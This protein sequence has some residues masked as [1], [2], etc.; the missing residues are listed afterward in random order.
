[1]EPPPGILV[2]T[3]AAEETGLSPPSFKPVVLFSVWEDHLC[4]SS[5]LFYIRSIISGRYY[6][7]DQGSLITKA[8]NKRNS[9]A[10]APAF[11][12]RRTSTL[13]E[14]R[15]ED[16]CLPFLPTT[17]CSMELPLQEKMSHR[18]QFWYRSTEIL[19]KG[20]GKPFK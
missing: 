18:L 6:Y 9:I 10:A 7:K 11:S 20:E 2:H 16:Q 12:Q 5:L 1:M 14:T 8:E 4:F 17:A 13:G 15:P 3:D 19:P